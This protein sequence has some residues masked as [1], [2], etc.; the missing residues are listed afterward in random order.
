LFVHDFNNVEF[1]ASEF[2]RRLGTSGLHA[3]GRRVAREERRSIL[4]PA[5]VRKY[6]GDMFW[7]EASGNPNGVK[8]V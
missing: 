2:D 5:L 7:R 3:V 6:E 8:V 1:D 4:P